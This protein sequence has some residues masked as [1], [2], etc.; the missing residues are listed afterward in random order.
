VARRALKKR[1]GLIVASFIAFQ[2]SVVCAA[3]GDRMIY[4]AGLVTPNTP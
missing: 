3:E 2:M 1:L 4:G